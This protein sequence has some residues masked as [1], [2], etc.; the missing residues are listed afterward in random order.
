[1]NITERDGVVML[2][3]CVLHLPWPCTYV[4]L[5]AFLDAVAHVS[6]TTHYFAL[7]CCPCDIPIV[8]CG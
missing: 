3:E 1:M 8:S 7:H 5:D 2:N 6:L 4:F